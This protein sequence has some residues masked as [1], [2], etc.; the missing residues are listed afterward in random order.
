M[1]DESLGVFQATRLVVGAALVCSVVTAGFA[2]LAVA[3]LPLAPEVEPARP[4]AAISALGSAAAPTT[5]ATNGHDARGLVR[6]VQDATLS[7]G[8][9][10]QIV[11][12]P[13]AEGGAFQKGDL[14]VEFDCDRPLAEKRAA[15]AATQVEQKT[16]ETNQEL[17]HF[18]SIGRFDLLISVSKLNK[19]KAELDALNA[20]IKQCKVTAPFTGWVIENK[21]HLYE[22]ASVGQPLV[23]IVDVSQLE[24]DVIVPSEWLLW[25]SQNQGFSF[26]VDETGV[27]HRAV[28]D[29]LLPTV[30]PVSKTVKVIGRILDDQTN[31]TVNTTP[32]MSGTA[33]FQRSEL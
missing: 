21:L 25:L 23:R 28:V 7:A 11:K 29:R 19:A 24:L 17:E 18:D 13:V 4:A 5:I 2:T 12:M 1:N 30:D 8:M 31:K 3:A 33:S 15:T 9:A 32:G 26:K 10:A 16:V 6:A 22:S 14:L 20:Q 27:V